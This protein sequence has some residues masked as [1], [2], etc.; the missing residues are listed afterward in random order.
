MFVLA[1]REYLLQTILDILELR[2]PEVYTGWIHSFLIL[3]EA[4][5]VP[6]KSKND[7]AKL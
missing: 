6:T 7:E 5:F 2:I 4:F 1:R 3:A